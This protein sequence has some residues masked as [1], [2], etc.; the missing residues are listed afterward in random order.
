VEV[1]VASVWL[2]IVSAMLWLGGMLFLTVVLVPVLKGVDPSLRGRLVDAVGVRF[3]MAG[4]I[5]LGLLVLTGFANVLMRG[6]SLTSPL[7]S[8]KLVLVGVILVLSFFHDF[9]VGPKATLAMERGGREAERL[10][11]ISSVIGRIN[12]L[13]AL[14]VVALGV[15]LVRGV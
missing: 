6:Y 5:C 1:Y 3:R 14:A 15:M 7:L 9:V 8:A 10:R 11:W 12:V 13:L 2:H 4:W